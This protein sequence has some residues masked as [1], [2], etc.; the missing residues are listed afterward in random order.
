M[1]FGDS[2]G[3]TLSGHKVSAEYSVTLIT[4]EIITGTYH[5]WGHIAL[6]YYF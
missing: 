1:V 2:Y 3:L 4:N 5:G 6:T